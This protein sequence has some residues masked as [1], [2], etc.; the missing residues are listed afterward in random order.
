MTVLLLLGPT[1]VGKSAVAVEV[2]SQVGGEIV[3]ADARALFG[4]LVLGTDRPPVEV[5][6]R[7]PHHLVGI[8]GLHD[9]Y[10]AAQ[11]RADCERI[12]ADIHARG[13]RAIV[14]GGS[15][16]YVRALT[17]G[18]F[19]GP[20]AD[21]LLRQELEQR[22][23]EELRVELARVDPEAARRIHP[24]DRVRTIRALEVWRKTGKPLSSF[25]GK[26]K[27]FPW[28][29]VKVGLVLEREEL[30]RRITAR[31]ERMFAQGLPD[32]V[33]ALVARGLSPDSQAGRTIGYREFFP[34]FRGEIDLEEVKRRIV[35]NTK[36]YARR[37]MAF[38]RAE[39]DVHWLDVT[40]LSAKAI[41][42]QVLELW[43]AQD[44]SLQ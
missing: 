42:D 22:P 11:F 40:G 34:Y 29:L 21:P 43:R 13:R 1:A 37:Q 19:A 10:D 16:L 2:A 30:H 24:A 4:D 31:V 39:Q 3:S 27:P 41:A 25:W 7:V 33:R 17:R 9:R 6:R 15:T 18:L 35:R 26:E 20:S 28:P 32:E 12:V 44:P 38:F 23:L 36:A 14:V 8:L 5:L